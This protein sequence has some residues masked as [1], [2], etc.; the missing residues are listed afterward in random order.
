[1]KQVKSLIDT[2]PALNLRYGTYYTTSSSAS[3]WFDTSAKLIGKYANDNDIPQK[4][5]NY[6][7]AGAWALLY[8]ENSILYSALLGNMWVD[9]TL[10]TGHIRTK[11]IFVSF[12]SSRSSYIM[13]VST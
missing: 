3:R 9:F 10:H 6:I 1:M 11:N 5:M 8:E 12:S 7:L 2:F 4:V 13:K